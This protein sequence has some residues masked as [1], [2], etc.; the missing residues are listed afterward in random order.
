[1][2]W[3]LLILSH[4][5]SVRDSRSVSRTGGFGSP[6]ALRLFGTSSLCSFQMSDI[7]EMSTAR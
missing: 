5:F 3:A 6:Q 1:M 2:G 4:H 7:S